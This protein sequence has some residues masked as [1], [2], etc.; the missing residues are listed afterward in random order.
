MTVKVRGERAMF[1][2]RGSGARV[3]RAYEMCP[4]EARQTKMRPPSTTIV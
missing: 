3:F 4:R 1:E 2:R